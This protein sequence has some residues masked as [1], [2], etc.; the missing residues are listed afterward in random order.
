MPDRP[1]ATDAILA[2][3]DAERWAEEL[4]T[5]APSD[6]LASLVC[7]E[8]AL[9]GVATVLAHRTQMRAI[10]LGLSPSQAHDIADRVL[11]C[12]LTA[13]E[14]MRRAYRKFADLH[15]DPFHLPPEQGRIGEGNE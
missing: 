7:L 12:G 5:T 6:L 4:F 11:H 1:V 10:E 3:T 13:A 2:F 9:V 8:P 14:M 15:D